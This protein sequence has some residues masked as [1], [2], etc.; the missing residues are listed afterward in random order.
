MDN[1][2]FAKKNLGKE[3]YTNT[4][5]DKGIIV[6]YRNNRWIII[7]FYN[8]DYNRW[9]TDPY[10]DNWEGDNFIIKSPMFKSYYYVEIS[11]IEIL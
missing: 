7:G 5:A 6:G 10:N 1:I 8:Y 9:S 4:F 3:C 2:E 11:D